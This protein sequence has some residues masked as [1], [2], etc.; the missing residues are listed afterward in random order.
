MVEKYKCYMNFVC[1]TNGNVNIYSKDGTLKNAFLKYEFPWKALT[2]SGLV[3]FI[4]NL[5]ISFLIFTLFT[6]VCAVSRRLHT[7]IKSLLYYVVD[8]SVWYLIL[9]CVKIKIDATKWSNIALIKLNIQY[10]RKLQIHYIFRNW[11]LLMVNRPHYNIVGGFPIH[12]LCDLF[13]VFNDKYILKTF[14]FMFVIS[15]KI[16]TLKHLWIKINRINNNNLSGLF[17]SLK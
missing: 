16:I 15:N 14:V 13:Y 10:S 17:N 11:K 8:N 2:C 3:N 6:D 5:K 1:S 12:K 7:L 9:T 4:N